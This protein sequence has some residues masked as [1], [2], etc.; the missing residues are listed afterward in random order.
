[1][2]VSGVTALAGEADEMVFHGV[3]DVSAAV[4]LDTA[5]FVTADD[6]T[7]F[8]RIYNINN[9]EEP[10]SLLDLNA[11]LAVDSEHPEGDIEA[12][13][14][15]GDRI[16]WIT[17]HGRNKD[18]KMRPGRHRF[19]CTRIYR[20][21]N[22]LRLVPAGQACTN[23]M[24]QFLTHSSPVTETIAKAAQFDEILSKKERRKLA[25]KEEGLNIE[26]LGFYPPNESLLIGLRNPLY[27][28]DG[29]KGDKA[30]VIELLNPR[31]V[32]GEGADAQFGRILV[33]DLDE[34]GIRGMEYSSQ[35]EVFYILAG[36]IDSETTFALYQW[37]GDFEHQ[38]VPLFVWPRNETFNP[39]GIT[40][41]SSDGLL[42]LFSDDGTLEIPVASSDEC[43][44]GELLNNGKCPNKYL[45]NPLRKT[46]RVRTVNPIESSK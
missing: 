1:M 18:G 16:Y 27:S 33:W 4:F 21:E 36:P 31:M 15:I 11:F 13:A 8:L 43:R 22:K 12:A 2:T 20:D 14:R 25:P 10:V 5:H 32:A 17:S 45:T 39:E 37:D 9:T 40:E 34:R 24:R 38:P 26:G 42:W 46:F 30:I 23:L 35:H 41:R 19:F 7:N 3:S 6:E 28:P 44:P 29:K